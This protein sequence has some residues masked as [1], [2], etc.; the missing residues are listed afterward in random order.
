MQL[1]E[2]LANQSTIKIQ[3]TETND[4]ENQLYNQ[5]ILTNEDWTAFKMS[6]EKAYP[7]YLIR[8]RNKFAYLTEA[9]ERLF[10]FIKLNLKSKEIAAILGISADS[11]K[12]TRSRLRKRL[13][14]PEE[15]DLDEFVLAF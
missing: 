12:K 9:E 5:R 2:E 6:F 4:F 7:G 3:E 11:V 1:E 10:I 15:T 13:E 14:L 8:L